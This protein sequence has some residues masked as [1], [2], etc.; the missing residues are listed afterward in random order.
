MRMGKRMGKICDYPL[1]RT[2]QNRDTRVFF[3][4][5]LTP[6]QNQR[7]EVVSCKGIANGYEVVT[8][9]TN[10]KGRYTVTDTYQGTDKGV[11]VTSVLHREHGSQTVPRFGKVFRLDEIFD[12]VT[13]FARS[14]E[15]YC[16]MKDQFCVQQVTCPVSAMTEP[17]IRPQESGNR[18]DCTTATL[19][20]GQLKVTFEA[21]GKPFELAVKPYTDRALT[22]M[23][24]REDEVRTGTYVTVQAF[25][26]G[27]GTGSCGPAIMP[28]FCYELKQDCTL[29]FLI[30]VE[31]V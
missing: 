10:G 6:W 16:D 12:T 11:L 17:N 18:M 8:R 13:Y 23:K 25:Q 30:R 9:L 31:E 15:S 2:F 27:I 26:Q 20:D 29:Q 22:G 4:R 1:A 14:G 3:R 19:T 7:T 28:E 21:V 24:H 5:P